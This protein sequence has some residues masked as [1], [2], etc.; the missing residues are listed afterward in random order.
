MSRIDEQL[1]E[2]ERT[3]ASLRAA[4]VNPY[5]ARSLPRV[6]TCAEIVTQEPS[7]SYRRPA[8]RIVR[9]RRHGGST[10]ITIHDGT[11]PLQLL[12][13]RDEL[14]L[15]R[16]KLLV[17]QFDTGDFIVVA[18]PLFKTKTEEPTVDVHEFG[19]L[20]K[21]LRPLPEKWHGL[22][23]VETRYRKRYLDLIANPEV[24][25][26]FKTRNSIMQA[27]R[28]FFTDKGFIEVE[29]PVL[30][31]L[32]SGAFA[33]PFVTHHKA[34]DADFYLR[35]ALELHLKR[36]LVGGFEKVFEI[37]RCFRNEGIDRNHNPEF[38]MLEA[39]WAYADYNGMMG[40]TEELFKHSIRSLIQQKQLIEPA[41]AAQ[42]GIGAPPFEKIT[43]RDAAKQFAH[44]NLDA[45]KSDADFSRMAQELHLDVSRGDPKRKIID[46]L[47][48]KKIVTH[49]ERPTFVIDHPAE[50]TPLAKRI[51]GDPG[52]VER[53]QLVIAGVEIANA[54]TELN[55]PVDQRA[56]FLEQE[57]IAMR[58]DDEAQRIDEDFIEALEYGMPPAAGIGIGIDRLVMLLTG[59]K[60]VKNVILFPTL[61]PKSND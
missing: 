11:G 4:G 21:A 51:E 20:G 18:G 53:F 41:L 35:V 61:K 26:L 22:T 33:V 24:R 6:E 39:Y 17:K 47:F 40:M 58:G 29:T 14:G 38:T 42:L 12:F 60:H 48:K 13:R 15:D 16:Y 55:D 23:D 50:L 57:A 32:P 8:G 5:P 52:Y 9:V 1:H 37:G 43:F 30:Q 10:F 31:T 49:I 36:L 7:S 27:V 34:L 25:Q 19:M 2:R 59:S 28:S 45:L 54:F 56:R 44:V 3:L 46:E